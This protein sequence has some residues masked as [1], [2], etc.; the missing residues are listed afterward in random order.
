MVR[1]VMDSSQNGSDP[2]PSDTGDPTDDDE[3]TPFQLECAVPIF[4]NCGRPPIVVDAPEGWCNAFAN[5]S[6]PAAEAQ[7]GLDTIIQ[8][9][10]T[11]LGSGSLFPVGTTILKWVAIDIFGNESTDT[12]ELKIVVND[13]HTPPA[14]EC[15]DDVTMDND[16]LMCGAV[17]M[18]IGPV[19]ESI[20]DN[21]PDNLSI[22]YTIEDESGM[23]IG[24]GINDA[25][26]F[27]FPAGE[28]TVTYVVKDQPLLLITEVIQDG[29]T[30]GIEITNFGPASYDISCLIIGREG[31]MPEAYVVDDI[32]VLPVG[33][34]YTQL[35]TNINIG[36]PAGYYIEYIDNEI[37]FVALNGHV[38]VE[39]DWTGTLTGTAF[40]RNG[41]QDTDSAEDWITS[42]DCDATTFGGMDPNLPILEDNMTTTSLQGKG[43]SEA[44]C[45]FKVTVIDNQPPYCSEFDTLVYTP[46]DLPILIGSGMCTSSVINVPNNFVVGDVNILNLEGTMSDAG[47]L[48]I[49]LT[50][51]NGTRIT[52][53]DNI[54]TGTSDFDIDLDD[55]AT[56]SLAMITCMPMGMGATFQPLQGL[57]AFIGEM[58]IG[59]WTLEI[60]SDGPGTGSLD[61]WEL[62]LMDQVT[63][64]QMDTIIN[65]DPGMCSGGFT[66]QHPIASDNCGF[67]QLE[68]SYTTEDDIQVPTGGIVNQGEFITEVF[69]VGTTTVIYTLTDGAGLTS[70][71]SFKVTVTDI[72]PPVLDPLSC[73]DIMVTLNPGECD[74]PIVF[75]ALSAP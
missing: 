42:N 31:T 8:V 52:L 45:S 2:N 44:S 16:P 56:N 53:L 14:I 38:S 17:V 37:D 25:S 28:N 9:D 32:T 59:D 67:A 51:P 61:S 39:Y 3:P 23:I 69:E 60:L 36:D 26:G 5:F 58:S 49:K 74:T 29:I 7:C 50:S 15:I 71:C 54:C 46:I 73:E 55:E 70:T 12:C 34:T 6:P 41:L 11:G 21:C 24:T 13:F 33:G 43:A 48:V 27:K 40:S 57:N 1:M 30:T 20:T 65:N 47:D 62:Q 72:D 18:G 68:I 75:P 22:T 4:T 35:F 63:Y 10:N 64:S 19:L 66:W